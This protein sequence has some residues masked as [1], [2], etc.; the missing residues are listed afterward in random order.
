MSSHPFYT[1][2]SNNLNISFIGPG[3]LPG[4]DIHKFILQITLERDFTVPFSLFI[5]SSKRNQN[6][7]SL[8]MPGDNSVYKIQQTKV[9][10]DNY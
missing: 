10:D 8:V 4:T 6:Q 1:H 5:H 7:F 2:E 9:M 3:T